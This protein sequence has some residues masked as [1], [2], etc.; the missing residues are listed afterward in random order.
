MRLYMIESNNE[1]ELDAALA[2]GWVLINYVKLNGKPRRLIATRNQSL[3]QYTPAGNGT[4]FIHPYLVVV[5]ERNTGWRA[6][7]RGRINN[8]T[9]IE[10]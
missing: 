8:W 3:Y 6:L 10:L 7:R 2:D 1:E 9:P 4:R 5:W